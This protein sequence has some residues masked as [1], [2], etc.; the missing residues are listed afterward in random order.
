M[1]D[2]NKLHEGVGTQEHYM[3]CPIQPIEYILANNLGFLEG[4]VIKYVTRFRS[5]NGI[6]DLKKAMQYLDW[7]IADELKKKEALESH[8]EE[9]QT[10]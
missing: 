2:K 9:L 10:Y 3:S 4:N 6:E 1:I 8:D 5:K 7:L